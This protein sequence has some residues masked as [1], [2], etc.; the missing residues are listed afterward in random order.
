MSTVHAILPDSITGVAIADDQAGLTAILKGDCPAVIWNRQPEPSFQSWIDGIDAD[1]L[2]NG[3][4]VLHHRHVHRAM[5]DLCD[6]AGTPQGT[7][8]DQLIDDVAALSTMFATLMTTEH[9]RLRLEAVST[10]ACRKFHVDAL[11][12][13]LVC[14]YR[15][16]GTQYGVSYTGADPA[17][18]FTT[19]TGAPILLRGTH[20]SEQTASGVLHRSPPIAGTGATRL[21]LVLDPILDQEITE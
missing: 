11:T 3:R 21:V 9:L 19:P 6:A 14:T 13:R 20:W 1:A 16:L 7:Q 10:N 17:R 4:R 18:V 12:A 15:G 5:T 2:P 8:R